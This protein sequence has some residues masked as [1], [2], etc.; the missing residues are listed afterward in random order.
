MRW[1]RL[2]I[3]WLLFAMTIIAVDCAVLRKPG[4]RV[5]PWLSPSFRA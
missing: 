1:F 3:A 4:G 5:L 2:S